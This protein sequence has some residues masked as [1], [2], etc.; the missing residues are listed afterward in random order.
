V[1]NIF[2]V[3]LAALLIDY[4]SK[5]VDCRMWIISLLTKLCHDQHL[6]QAGGIS[7]LQQG[8]RRR[9]KAGTTPTSAIDRDRA[10]SSAAGHVTSVDL[11]LGFKVTDPESWFMSRCGEERC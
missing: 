5:T 11:E 7:M 9:V 8:G 10:A 6:F 1:Q 3:A 2:L 4:G